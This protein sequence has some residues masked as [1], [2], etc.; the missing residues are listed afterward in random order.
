[1]TRLARLALVLGT[2][3]LL[4]PAFAA[5]APRMWV[6]FQDDPNFRWKSDRMQAL[7][8]AARAH[9]TVLRTLVDWAAVA[10]ARPAHASDSFDP[11][12]RLDDLDEFVR[13]AQDRGAEVILTIWGTPSWAD[14]GAGPNHVPTELADLT[15]FAHALASRYSGTRPGY[16][17]VR[18]YSVWSEPNRKRFLTPQQNAAGLY[19]GLYRAAYAGIKSGSPRAQVAIG[20]TSAWGDTDPARFAERLART[21]PRLRFDAWALHPYS[22]DPAAPPGKAAP[23]P[24]VTLSQLPRFEKSLD[25]WF[26]RKGIP[27]WITDFSYETSPEK[28]Y[29]VPYATQ[30]A[31]VRQAL[32]IASKDARVQMF[33]WSILRDDTTSPRSSGLLKLDGTEKPAY[34][35]FAAAAAPLDARNTVLSVQ[36]GVPNPVIRVS[37]LSIA[38]HSPAG[39]RI[40]IRLS[41]FDG[42]KS[43]GTQLPVAPLGVDGWFSVPLQLVPRAGHRYR[44]LVDAA[45]ADGNR[46]LRTI[47][48]LAS[49]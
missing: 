19:A 9:A 34:A 27:I 5:A 38:A 1:M 31:Y 39:T 37:A 4:V 28:S 15:A 42:T 13:G 8:S 36:A 3:A 6:G 26:G 32:A 7:D 16:P 43:L 46:A 33:V 12:Y 14:G 23:W 40:G 30:A 47:E 18:F 45:D 25:G 22:R 41:V 10:P 2:I 20:E 48:L 17:F 29:G 35:A 24:T 49:N 21:R 44:V 11:A